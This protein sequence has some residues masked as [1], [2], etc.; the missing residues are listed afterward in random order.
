MFL[1]TLIFVVIG[2][3]LTVLT[4]V[5]FKVVVASVVMILIICFFSYL[6]S[7]AYLVNYY[8]TKNKSYFTKRVKISIGD[9]I[10]EEE[11]LNN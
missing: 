10:S 1:K 4:L 6:L 7:C 9:D 11:K 5:L 3:V 8:E 2:V